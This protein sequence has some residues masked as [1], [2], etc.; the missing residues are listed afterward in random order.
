MPRLDLSAAE[1]RAY[2]PEVAEPGDFDQFWA[3]TL[4]DHSPRETRAE[5]TPEPSRLKLVDVWDVSFGGFD[6]HPIKAWLIAPKGASGPLPGLIEFIG[7]GGGRGLPHERLAWATAGYA[8]LY[9]DL[10]GQGSAWGAGGETPDPVGSGPAAP[11]SMT[12]GIESPGT[13]FYRRVFVDAVRA[14]E[15]MRQLPLVDAERLTVAGG[16][17]GGGITIAV[18]GLTQGLAAALPDVPFLCHFERAVGFTDQGPYPE[19]VRYLSV[20]RGAESQVFDTLSYF[21]GVNF[22]RRASAPALF[23]VGHLDPV[24]PPSTVYAA[25]NHWAA[26]AEMVDYPFNEHEGGGP[27]QWQ[28]QADWLAERV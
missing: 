11:G 15:V 21:D 18:A 23:S 5:L 10:R 7:Y 26:E 19:I 3:S 1:L 4:A 8:Y 16:S 12:R 17:Q 27:F 22:A 6:N 24:C 13:Y 20:H 2:R 9:V 25:F 28:R 14:V